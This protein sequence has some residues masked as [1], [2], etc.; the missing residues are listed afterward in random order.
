MNMRRTRTCE[1][2]GK[3]LGGTVGKCFECGGEKPSPS[4]EERLADAV[5]WKV[6]LG[7]PYGMIQEAHE[8]HSVADST[9]D[10]EQVGDS[11]G[12]A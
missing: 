11:E 7:V 2:C 4:R 10:S 5:Y 8:G 12:D 1:E 9:R 6:E 3:Q